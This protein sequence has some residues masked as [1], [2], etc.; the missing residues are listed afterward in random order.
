MAAS[1]GVITE[2]FVGALVR[3]RY[4]FIV[5]PQSE[6]QCF[7]TVKSF[8]KL[9]P[10]PNVFGAMDGTHVK[11]VALED[12]TVDFLDRSQCY[13]MECQEVFDGS[14]KFLSVSAGFP[15]SLHDT[16]ILR[17]TWL[18]QLANNRDILQTP[19]FHLSATASVKSFVV[20][21]A[22]YPM[23]EWLIKPYQY[24]PNIDQ[25]EKIFNLALSLARMII[26]GAFGVLK[27]RWRILLNKVSLEPSFVANIVVACCVL[28]NVCQG[29]SEPAEEVADPYIIL[30][31]VWSRH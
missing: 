3:L 19:L 27:G 2:G 7:N 11:A 10:L 4:Q 15:G 12:R 14:I 22:A 13:D 5:R 29:H 28:H 21:D 9:S 23:H 24:A 26:E 1:V 20:G 18:N 30:Y 17:N 31:P 8:G 25:E 16:R 6:R